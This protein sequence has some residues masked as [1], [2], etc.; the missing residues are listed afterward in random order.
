VFLKHY[1]SQPQEHVNMTLETNVGVFFSM[2]EDGERRYSGVTKL[3]SV[4]RSAGRR[5]TGELMR[6][7]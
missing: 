3:A 7:V 1:F 4:A 6:F 2:I 5:A